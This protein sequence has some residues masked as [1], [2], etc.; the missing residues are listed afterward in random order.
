MK[1]EK[2]GSRRRQS[3]SESDVQCARWDEGGWNSFQQVVI[4]EKNEI[5]GCAELEMVRDQ[6]YYSREPISNC[7]WCSVMSIQ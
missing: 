6:N 2:K 4:L 5:V 3:G 7:S 1:E